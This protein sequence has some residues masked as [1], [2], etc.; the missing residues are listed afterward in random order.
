MKSLRTSSARL[1]YFYPYRKKRSYHLAVEL[2]FLARHA[3]E[4][5]PRKFIRGVVK[6][7]AISMTIAK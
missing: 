4:K 3:L 2:T 5:F 6:L 1:R 7:R